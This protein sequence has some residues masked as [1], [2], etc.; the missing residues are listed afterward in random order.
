MER[1]L[2]QCQQLLQEVKGEQEQTAEG[3]HAADA[4]IQALTLSKEEASLATD[5][6]PLFTC[7]FAFSVS[8][9]VLAFKQ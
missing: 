2:R 6:L 7:P 8:F 9:V 5:P 1:S 4:Q 3:L